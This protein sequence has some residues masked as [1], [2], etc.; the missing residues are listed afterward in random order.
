MTEE[1]QYPEGHPKRIEQ[2]PQGI[3]NDVPS[4]SKKKRRRKMIEPYMLLVNL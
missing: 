4:P 2:D 3:N 1:P